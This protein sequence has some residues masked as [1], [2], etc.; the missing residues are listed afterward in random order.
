MDA[1]ELRF[2][3]NCKAKVFKRFILDNSKEDEETEDKNNN[4]RSRKADTSLL[5]EKVSLSDIIMESWTGSQVYQ[6]V[7]E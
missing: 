6:L 2:I 1:Q 7:N 5:D 4:S 3:H